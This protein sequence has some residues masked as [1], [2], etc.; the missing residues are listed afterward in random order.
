MQLDWFTTVA[1]IV[2][3]LILVA[4]LK[5]FLY[6][7]I[8]RAMEAREA[9]IAARVQAA[10]DQL[11]TAE[12]QAAHYDEQLQAL[13]NTRES[14]LGQAVEAAES[15]RQRLLD[16]ARQEQRQ[17]QA[18]WRQALEQEQTAFLQELRQRAGLHVVSVARHV[19]EDLA[20]AELEKIIIQVF[21]DRLRALDDEARHAFVSAG[22][23]EPVDVVIRST[24]P[25]PLEV[26]Q[27]L[28]QAVHAHLAD[29]AQVE[30]ATASALL[31]GI[32]LEVNGRK[33]AWHMAHYMDHVEE[34]FTKM[35]RQD[36]EPRAAMAL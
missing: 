34:Q 28:I 19:V 17:L 3:F 24:F 9:H 18:R 33:L 35:L 16:Q 6:G 4:L 10:Q 26:Q 27:A 13:K 14:I 21:L 29:S 12:R 22:S 25:M 15:E 23:E 31:C 36:V 30:F 8:I 2:N 20:N 11:T 1:Q 5:R 32:E 7:P